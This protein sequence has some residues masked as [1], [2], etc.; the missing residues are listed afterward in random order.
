[1]RIRAEP[2]PD[3]LRHAVEAGGRYA[4]VPANFQVHAAPRRA[5]GPLAMTVS[6][7]CTVLS[8]LGIGVM[9]SAISPL[10]RQLHRIA[11]LV[12]RGHFS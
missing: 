4:I 10:L 11:A 8:A 6:I 9:G 12:S 2:P 3:T 7:T 1:M 5:S